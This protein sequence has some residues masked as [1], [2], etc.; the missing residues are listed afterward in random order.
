[1]FAVRVGH[2]HRDTEWFGA[3]AHDFD[4]LRKTVG[5]DEKH[6]AA[7]AVHPVQQR[8]RLGRGGRFIEHR[9]VRDFHAGEI[10]DHRLEVHECFEA[11]L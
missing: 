1:M 3:G 4:R 6:V 11:A 7:V 10:G 8:H 2:E 9:R 5:V